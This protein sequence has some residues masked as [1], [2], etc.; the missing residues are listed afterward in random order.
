M[1]P[2]KETEA[3]ALPH[4]VLHL[5]KSEADSQTFL[6]LPTLRD[7]VIEQHPDWNPGTEERRRLYCRIRNSIQT[8]QLIDKK[9]LVKEALTVRKTKMIKLYYNVQPV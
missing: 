1:Q 6:T 9:V 7:M 5:L 4:I 8:V 3:P 2:P